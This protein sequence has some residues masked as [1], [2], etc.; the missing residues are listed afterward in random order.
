MI[1]I[2]FLLRRRAGMTPDEFHRYW[3][4]QHGPLVASYATALGVRRYIQLHATDAATGAVVAQSRGCEPCDWDGVA[5]VWFDSEDA[6]GATAATPEGRA[7][8]TALLEDERRFLD[9]ERCQLF[10]SDDHTVVG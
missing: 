10:I 4:E 9:L 2:T 1:A 6:L 3:R 5:L 7:A 8:G